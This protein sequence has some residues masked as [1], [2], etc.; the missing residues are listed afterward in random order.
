[1]ILVSVLTGVY[2]CIMFMPAVIINFSIT[3]ILFIPRRILRVI[4]FLAL[5]YLIYSA[6]LETVISYL[7]IM[8]E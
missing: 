2:N 1:M 5:G 6:S 8:I 3:L 7:K 4:T